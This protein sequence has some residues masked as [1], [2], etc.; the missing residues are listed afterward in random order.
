LHIEKL[1]L[2]GENIKIEKLIKKEK[3]ELILSALTEIGGDALKPVKERL[4]DNF[5]YGE[6]RLVRAHAL[7]I[8]K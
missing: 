5:S 3:I 8:K 4:G 2:S 7:S 1:I 6:I